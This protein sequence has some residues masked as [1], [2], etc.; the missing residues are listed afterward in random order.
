MRANKSFNR[1]ITTHHSLVSCRR[2]KKAAAIIEG[3]LGVWLVIGFSVAASLLIL[4]IGGIGTGQNKLAFVTQQAARFAAMHYNDPAVSSQTATFVQTCMQQCGMPNSQSASVTVSTTTVNNQPAETVLVSISAPLFGN[5]SWLPGQTT[6]SD[7]E[8][9]IIA[10]GSPVAYA[11]WPGAGPGGTAWSGP[12]T[13]IGNTGVGIISPVS[14]VSNM[15]PSVGTVNGLPLIQ[16]GNNTSPPSSAV[17]GYVN[18]KG[19]TLP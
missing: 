4:D 9:Y 13:G 6:M 5:G 2:R 3:M 11:W 14:Y 8:A 7:Q 10:M 15:P 16:M 1:S 18:S 19:V 12:G 17:S